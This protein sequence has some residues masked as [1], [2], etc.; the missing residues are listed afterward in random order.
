MKTLIYLLLV[1]SLSS[2]CIL[3]DFCETIE[4]PELDQE[5]SYGIVFE[6]TIYYSHTSVI[7][8]MMEYREWCEDNPYDLAYDPFSIFRY[9]DHNFKNGYLSDTLTFKKSATLEGF[10][11]WYLEYKK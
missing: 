2:C 7:D 10:L 8:L 9:G 11:D 1:F 4:N 3:Q 5:Y 6:D